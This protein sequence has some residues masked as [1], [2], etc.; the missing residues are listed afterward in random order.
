MTSVA[1]ETRTNRGM[2][3]AVEEQQ[4]TFGAAIGNIGTLAHRNLLKFARNRQLVLVSIVQPLTNMMMFAYV[5]N[6]VA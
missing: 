2:A 4:L 5:L 6:Q 3:G 1:D